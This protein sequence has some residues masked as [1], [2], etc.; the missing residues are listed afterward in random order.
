MNPNYTEFKFPQIK[1]HPWNKVFRSRTAPDLID[2]VSKI[3]VYDPAQRPADLET[4]LH[5]V[6]DELRD[7][8]CR[9][10]NGDPLPH[11]FNFTDGKSL[12]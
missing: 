9:L 5:P 7:E 3:L 4:L 11:M 6:F 12:S 2:L 1:A 8:K 10:P